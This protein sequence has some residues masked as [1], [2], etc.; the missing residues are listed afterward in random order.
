LIS[1]S[2]SALSKIKHQFY[3]DDHL[4]AIP[5]DPVKLRKFI[6]QQERAIKGLEDPSEQVSVLGEVAVYRRILGDLAGA[7]KILTECLRVIE[8]ENLGVWKELQQKIRLAHV[9]QDMSDFS[10]SNGLL[11]DVLRVCDERSDLETMR[12]FALQH[13]GKN[14]FAQERYREALDLFESAKDLRIKLE[15]PQEQIDSTQ[16]AIDRT[17]AQIEKQQIGLRNKS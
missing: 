7:E 6:V 13:S 12:A 1:Y 4:R 8:T 9:Y 10:K 2:E 11:K 15:V 3:Y 5:C 17:C 16:T 14:F